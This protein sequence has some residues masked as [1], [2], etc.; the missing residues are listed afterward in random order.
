[1]IDWKS[2]AWTSGNPSVAED[3]LWLTA[4]G[5]D[6]RGDDQAVSISMTAAMPTP[7]QP[8]GDVPLVDITST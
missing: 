4:G 2:S 8:V 6:R 3:W 5:C 7:S 1:M